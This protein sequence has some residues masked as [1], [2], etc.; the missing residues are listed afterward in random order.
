MDDGKNGEFFTVTG[1]PVISL[2]RAFTI[3]DKILK[4]HTFRFKYRARN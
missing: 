2:V 3:T 4:G 1:D